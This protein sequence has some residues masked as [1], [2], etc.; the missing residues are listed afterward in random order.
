MEAENIPDVFNVRKAL[1]LSKQEVI[2]EY[3][4]IANTP[5]REFVP[6]SEAAYEQAVMIRA[7]YGD[8]YPRLEIVNNK[9]KQRNR[10]INGK[11][12]DYKPKLAYKA[13]ILLD[14]CEL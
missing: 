8:N 12:E 9:Y 3:E 7:I 10:Y 1:N 13:H 6:F 2:S 4:R 11:K 14:M 5:V